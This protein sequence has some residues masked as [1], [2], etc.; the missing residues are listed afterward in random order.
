MEGSLIDEGSPLSRVSTFG[1]DDPRL[2]STCLVEYS[3]PP[4][5]LYNLYC[6]QLSL[7]AHRRVH[8]C[9][10]LLFGVGRPLGKHLDTTTNA[11]SNK[12]NGGANDGC[13]EK[14]TPLLVC[15]R[16]GN[17]SDDETASC[18]TGIYHGLWPDGRRNP[19]SSETNRG[20][21]LAHTVSKKWQCRRSG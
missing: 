21:M 20:W 18:P 16:E 13:K 3:R 10:K 12:G 11:G 19:W 7:C 9:A 2:H 17:R 14:E 5:T 4:H 1:D 6:F 15:I 8:I